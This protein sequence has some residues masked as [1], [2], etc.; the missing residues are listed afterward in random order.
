MTLTDMMRR[1]GRTLKA[2]YDDSHMAARIAVGVWLLSMIMV[3]ILKW[4]LGA[5]RAIP[6]TV[7]ITVLLQ[8]LV[9]IIVMVQSVGA[10][11]TAWMFAVVAVGT[12][13]AEWIGS[14]TGIPFGRYHYTD[15][16]QPQ[17]EGVPLLI[18]VA[19]LMMIGPG[20]AVARRLTGRYGGIVF[21]LVAGLA[22]TAWDLYLDP[23]M[24]SWG[25]W[26]WE[27]PV[28]YFGI[29]WV[30]FL[31]W[32]LTAT[33]ITL[34]A[35][36]RDLDTGPLLLIYLL[37]WIM[38]AGGLALFWGL[39]GPALAGFTVMGAFGLAALLVPDQV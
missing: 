20:W 2:A 25:L 10:G 1:A 15:V 13:L 26:Q 4:T 7:P 5:D 32:I 27:N 39:P 28:G 35:A 33:L 16:L 29:P 24:V 21:A 31:G 38:S 34:V 36:P 6:I 37:T 22:L 19:W 23:Q 18:P 3:P 14:T 11:R 17:I 30:N 9:S 12:F 8:A